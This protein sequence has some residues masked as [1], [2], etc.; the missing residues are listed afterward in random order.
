MLALAAIPLLRGF[1]PLGATAA[2]TLALALLMALRGPAGTGG[3]IP[4]AFDLAL[5][6]LAGL[7]LSAQWRRRQEPRG[8]R[9]RVLTGGDRAVRRGRALGR[10]H[11]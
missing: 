9:L 11:A 7:S 3:A 1:S 10:H 5:A 6:M 8:R 4:L 2:T